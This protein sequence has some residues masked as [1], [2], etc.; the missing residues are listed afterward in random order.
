M[1]EYVRLYS[2]EVGESHFETVDAALLEF[3][4]APPAP[5]LDVSELVPAQGFLFLRLPCGWAGDWH[6]S[7]KRQFACVLKGRVEITASDGETRR[8]APG[9][10]LLQEDTAGKGHASKVI[11]DADLL[12]SVTQ[13]D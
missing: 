10:C 11:G 9:D 7:P 8:F 5:P 1:V 6:P 12:L 4:F 3:D 2:D 13:L